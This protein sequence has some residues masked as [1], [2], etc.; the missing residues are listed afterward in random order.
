[1]KGDHYTIFQQPLVKEFAHV[2]S[3]FLKNINRENKNSLLE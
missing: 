1:M 2:F 3:E